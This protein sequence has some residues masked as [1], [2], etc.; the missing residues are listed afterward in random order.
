MSS[1]KPPRF[2]SQFEAY[3]ASILLGRGCKYAY[4]SERIPFLQPEM[5][6]TYCPDFVIEDQGFFIEAKGIFSARDR[7]KH[8]WIQDQTDFD[9]R[10]CFMNAN[11][12]IRKGSKTKYS[13][14]CEANNFIWCDKNIP[15][16]WMKQ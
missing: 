9:I 7:K 5:K 4:E 3:I 8:L 10:F 6:K 16:D 1:N 2:R 13:D 12:K 14:W 11:N 15:L